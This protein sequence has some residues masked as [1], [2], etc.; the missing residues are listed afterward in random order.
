METGR[1]EPFCV[2]DGAKAQRLKGTCTGSPRQAV[3]EEGLESESL[4]SW[5]IA[6]FFLLSSL[7]H[8]LFPSSS[9]P[10]F[11]SFFSPL[12]PPL[13]SPLVS[14]HSLHLSFLVSLLCPL[15]SRSSA[16]LRH[17]PAFKVQF[18]SDQRRS[19]QTSALVMPR[20]N[21]RQGTPRFRIASLEPWS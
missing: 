12:P 15:D 18:Q 10:V 1:P 17:Q 2:Q 13:P 6:V 8:L 14:L 16:G 7:H 3:G 19:T 20:E 9:P 4:D 11:I 5:A 21:S